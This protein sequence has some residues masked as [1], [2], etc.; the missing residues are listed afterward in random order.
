MSELKR[1]ESHFKPVLLLTGIYETLGE[2]IIKQRVI[3]R[4][5]TLLILVA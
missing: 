4:K 1:Y 3:Q 2:T 5:K